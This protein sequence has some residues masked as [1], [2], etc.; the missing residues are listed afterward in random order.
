MSQYWNDRHGTTEK[1]DALFEKIRNQIKI[2]QKFTTEDLTF[3]NNG[4]DILIDVYKNNVE[5]IIVE[6][7]SI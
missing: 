5:S 4:V 2:D 6:E 7:S 1:M 3:I